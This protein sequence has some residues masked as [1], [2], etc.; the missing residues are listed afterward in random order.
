M[1]VIIM[2]VMMMVGDH[3]VVH[4]DDSCGG[5]CYRRW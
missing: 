1:V 2:M 3:L 5:V 4:A